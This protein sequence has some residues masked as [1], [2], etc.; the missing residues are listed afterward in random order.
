VD[1][2][3]VQD[4]N[5]AVV[6]VRGNAA[7]ADGSLVTGN[8]FRVLGLASGGRHRPSPTSQTPSM[9]CPKARPSR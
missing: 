7:N 9:R 8:F 4:F 3:G 5:R 1:L 2:S 6:M